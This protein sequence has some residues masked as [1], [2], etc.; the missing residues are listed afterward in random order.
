MTLQCTPQIAGCQVLF[1]YFQ[2]L[3]FPHRA[4]FS[5]MP[6][7]TYSI[8]LDGS[9]FHTWSPPPSWSP[10]FGDRIAVPYGGRLRSFVIIG[11]SE[12]DCTIVVQLCEP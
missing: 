8:E 6:R 7:K 3:T 4:V 5:G 12:E 11:G 1:L 2:C 10:R 9:P